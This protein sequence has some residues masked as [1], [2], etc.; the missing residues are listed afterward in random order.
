MK[1]LLILFVFVSACVQTHKNH[2]GMF[3]ENV[4]KKEHLTASSNSEVFFLGSPALED[5]S[6]LKLK[7]FAHVINLRDISK[8]DE[9]RNR[10]VLE[11]AGLSYTS[12][13]FDRKQPSV[14]DLDKI[15]KELLKNKKGKTLIHCAGE[16]EAKDLADKLDV[17][18]QKP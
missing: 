14:V 18:R 12:I 13:S 8:Q 1:V 6:A 3:S 17:Q 9:K 7:G 5:V 4:S 10:K 16:S 15:T 11:S 2:E